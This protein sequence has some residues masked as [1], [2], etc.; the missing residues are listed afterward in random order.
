[1][2]GLH[3]SPVS[4]NG[5]DVKSFSISF[6]KIMLRLLSYMTSREVPNKSGKW[7]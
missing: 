2:H 7:G 1:M 6:I 4:H 3:L 5:L